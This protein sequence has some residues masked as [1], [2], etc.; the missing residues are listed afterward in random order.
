MSESNIFFKLYVI[1][2]HIILLFNLIVGIIM[3]TKTDPFTELHYKW[4]QLLVGI[5][6]FI[7]SIELL[8]S[9]CLCVLYLAFVTT[10]TR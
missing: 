7:L 4:G 2:F 6:G 10:N 1:S 9:I 3:M 8:Y 5:T